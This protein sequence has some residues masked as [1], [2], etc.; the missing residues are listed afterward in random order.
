MTAQLPPGTLKKVHA[1]MA[2]AFG[3]ERAQ[4]ALEIWQRDYADKD[5]FGVVNFVREQGPAFGLND[6]SQARRLRLA[7]FQILLV[8]ADSSA[9]GTKQGAQGATTQ[10]GDAGTNADIGEARA[11]VANTM[12][13][14]LG[15]AARGSSDLFAK[16]LAEEVDKAQLD[17]TTAH[18][19]K[20][21][22]GASEPALPPNDN[23]PLRAAVTAVYI[24]LCED[25]GPAGADRALK[26]AKRAA[27]ELDA[28]SQVSPSDLL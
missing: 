11:R 28:A 18:A 19:L 9:D 1:I 14:K 27:E 13:Q 3:P 25:V 15:R 20:T 2:R 24:A 16:V 21:W 4:E 17:S 12:V 6:A 23:T 26:Q 5:S 7:L 22:D 10:E 8:E